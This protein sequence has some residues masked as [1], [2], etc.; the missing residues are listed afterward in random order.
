[1]A[2]KELSG[3]LKLQIQ[4]K[5]L[6][7]VPTSLMDKPEEEK[8]KKPKDKKPKKAV[9]AGKKKVKKV[10]IADEALSP[11]DR[12]QTFTQPQSTSVGIGGLESDTPSSEREEEEDDREDQAV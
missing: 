11:E 7:E 2:E 12:A 10:A 8:T 4:I 3:S 1:M 6:P 5:P 9:T